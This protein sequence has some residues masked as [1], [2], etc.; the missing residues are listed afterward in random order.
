MTINEIEKAVLNCKKGSNQHI[1][2]RRPMETYKKVAD[3]VEKETEMIVRFGINY[4]NLAS[5]KKG[6]AD[7]TLPQTNQGFLGAK[8]WVV[9]MENYI[10]QSKYKTLLRCY[11]SNLFAYKV[12]KYYLNGKEVKK[13]DIIDL[14]T[15]KEFPK[16]PSREIPLFDIDINSVVAIGK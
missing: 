10:L 6:R 14:C 3:K 15:A 4:D 11:Q 12:V 8:S 7:G 16:T 13:E 9:G 5:T 1:V 2:F